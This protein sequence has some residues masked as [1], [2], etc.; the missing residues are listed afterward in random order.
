MDFETNLCRCVCVCSASVGTTLRWMTNKPL[1]T[2]LAKARY[3]LGT[4]A[5]VC[6]TGSA[7]LIQGNTMESKQL[8]FSD[9]H[10]HTQTQIHRKCKS[11]NA[12]IICWS[13]LM[14]AFLLALFAYLQKCNRPRH[15]LDPRNH[16]SLCSGKQTTNLLIRRWCAPESLVKTFPSQL[17]VDA[18]GCW[19]LLCC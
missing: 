5:R 10:R 17:Q 1:V 16:W 13:R 6:D 8:A 2:E 9:T 14:P 15:W 4:L 19:E 18:G 7:E 12:N 11:L 3:P